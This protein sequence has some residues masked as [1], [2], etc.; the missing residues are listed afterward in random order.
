[1]AKSPGRSGKKL[2]LRVVLFGIV[3][4]ALLVTLFTNEHYIRET[5]AKGGVY[6]IL[7]IVTVFLFSYVHGNFADSFMT[8]LG[9]VPKKKH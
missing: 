5:W 1:M 9:M 7:P 8:S 6:A 2:Y 4:L 3:S